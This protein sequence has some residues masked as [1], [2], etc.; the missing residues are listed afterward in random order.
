[1]IS[2]SLRN[3]R[4]VHVILL[5][6]IAGYAYVA[7]MTLKPTTDAP[8][9]LVKAFPIVAVAEV[10]I[11]FAIRRKL[12]RSA[13][14]GL[15]RHAGDATALGQWRK[16][17][18]FSMVMMVSVALYG[19]ALRFVGGSRRVAAPFFVAAVILM[20]LWRPRLDEVISGANPSLPPMN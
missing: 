12:L 14:E 7:E 15:Q 4:I 9:I 3:M 16:A 5:A 20:L 18:L 2:A 1:M 10:V 6:A 17:N 19:L 13:M 8:P 11:T